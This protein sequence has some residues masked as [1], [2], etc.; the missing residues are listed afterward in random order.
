MILMDLYP[1]FHVAILRHMHMFCVTRHISV[2]V[3]VLLV[4]E[5]VSEFVLLL[6]LVLVHVMTTIIFYIY[7]IHV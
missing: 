5:V 4:T 3:T 2:H 6:S 7:Y 1:Q